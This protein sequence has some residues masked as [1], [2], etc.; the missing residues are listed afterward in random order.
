MDEVSDSG[1][2]VDKM[3]GDIMA[4]VCLVGALIVFV[5]VLLWSEAAADAETVRH[6]RDAAITAVAT[7]K[8]ERDA[9]KVAAATAE[10]RERSA[11]HASIRQK[12]KIEQLEKQARHKI[13]VVF[14]FDGSL[15]ME[16]GRRPSIQAISSLCRVLPE[17][18]DD[19]RIG[20]FFYTLPHVTPS[21]M[22][23][24]KKPAVD[25]GASYRKTVAF[26]RSKTLV[27]GQVDNYGM[28]LRAIAECQ[29][30]GGSGRRQVIVLVSDATLEET[31]YHGPQ[32]S[33]AE[34]S[35]AIKAWRSGAT[36]DRILLT[37]NP[38]GNAIAADGELS[39]LAMEGGGHLCKNGPQLLELLLV[40]ALK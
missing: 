25:R 12:Q 26:L 27:N 6:E 29:R 17:V 31:K 7:T 11:R 14:L 38:S 21:G 18:A 40:A 23:S 9:A 20:C 37:Y 5:F 34:A 10:Q 32:R 39:T 13:D 15:S 28:L 22:V 24:V 19:V 30:Q 33:L 3:F 2:L 35:R 16:S 8:Q 1:A 36:E 4:A